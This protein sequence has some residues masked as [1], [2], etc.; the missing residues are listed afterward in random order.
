MLRLKRKIVTADALFCSRP[1]AKT[2]LDQGGNYVL[3]LKKKR[4]RGT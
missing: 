3:A 1:F 2:V 4:K